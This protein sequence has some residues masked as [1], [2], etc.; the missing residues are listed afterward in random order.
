MSRMEVRTG[1]Y[2]IQ[3]RDVDLLSDVSAIRI[4][5]EGQPWWHTQLPAELVEDTEIFNNS[6]R[7]WLI[8]E[9]ENALKERG[10]GDGIA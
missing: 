6:F 8:D 1:E 9:Y 2:E 5:R 4:R 7:E 3:V 10:E